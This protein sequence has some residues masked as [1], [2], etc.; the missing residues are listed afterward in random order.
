MP[1]KEKK[2]DDKFRFITIIKCEKCQTEIEDP[3]PCPKCK[4]LTFNYTF[5]VVPI[6]K[7]K[8]K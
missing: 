4:N 1:E 7:Q 8:E 5:K 6:G 3:Q 2:Q